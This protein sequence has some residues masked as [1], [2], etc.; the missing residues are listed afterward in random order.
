[1]IHF[2]SASLYLIVDLNNNLFDGFD[3]YSIH[4]SGS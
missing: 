2:V 1:M 4:Y 3:S